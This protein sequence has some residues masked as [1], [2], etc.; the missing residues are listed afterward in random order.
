MKTFPER[1]Y[2]YRISVAPRKKAQSHV[3]IK[4]WGAMRYGKLSEL[5]PY[6]EIKLEGYIYL[7]KSHDLANYPSAHDVLRYRAVLSRRHTT[8]TKRRRLNPP[9]SSTNAPAG[10]GRKRQDLTKPADIT[11]DV[12]KPCISI[13]HINQ[14]HSIDST[15][16]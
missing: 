6:E 13:S 16:S 14:L 5:I 12:Q 11:K 1:R 9:D 2:S 15:N 3:K 8:L 4:I 10:V 7:S